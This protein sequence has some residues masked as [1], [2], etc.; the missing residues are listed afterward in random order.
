MMNIV[1][2]GLSH[3]TAEVDVRERYAFADRELP[4]ALRRLKGL[5]G[6]TES[7]IVSTCNRV[8]HYLVVTGPESQKRASDMFRAYCT[9][10][11]R[12][13]PGDGEEHFYHHDAPG[14]VEH[15]FRVVCGLDSMV[16]GETE[17]L[18]Q[19]KRAYL[20]AAAAGTT[21]RVLNKLFQRAFQVAK[22]V[23]SRT[24]I[25]RGSVSVGSVAV[26]M[27]E[28]LF[29]SLSRCRV[30]VLGTGETGKLTTRVLLSRGVP[31]AGLVVANRS[32][33]SARLLAAE[34]GGEAVP[35]DTWENEAGAVD[36]LVTSTS[37]SGFV[38]TK[39]RLESLMASRP[40]R[41][42]FV[43]DIAVPR[44]VEPSANDLE[45]VY[46]YDID[47]LQEIARSA[48]DARR[49]ELTA[50]EKMIGGHVREFADWSERELARLAAV[51]PEVQEAAA[52]PVENEE[53]RV[54][55]ADAAIPELQPYWSPGRPAAR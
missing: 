11:G 52:S 54:E 24:N 38:V 34:L 1:C 25:G 12:G 20:Q 28:R 15:L 43:I 22:Q 17:I 2:F 41:P 10:E 23:R 27:A 8:E 29:G 7:L 55:K 4:A 30:L 42:L 47:S 9:A 5:A 14:S 35:F 32:P 49:S 16:L 21:S 39:A 13:E 48:M 40:D 31:P 6:V 51:G 45:G 3:H 50:C 53:A 19:V 37:A 36:I 18:G 46:L 44:D 33:D 26:D